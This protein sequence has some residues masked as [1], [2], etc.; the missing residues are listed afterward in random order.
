MYFFFSNKRSVVVSKPSK[1]ALSLIVVSR[2]CVK[3]FV[4]LAIEFLMIG[5]T[6]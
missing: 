3:N 4:S 1:V 2:I 6:G 5:W